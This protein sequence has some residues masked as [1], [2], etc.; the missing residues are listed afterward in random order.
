MNREERLVDYLKDKNKYIHNALDW[1]EFG[2]KKGIT[3][4][5]CQRILG[6]TELRKSIS[7]L[8]HKYEIKD[9]WEYETNRFGVPVKFKRYFIIG[10][11][12]DKQCTGKNNW[13]K[14]I[15]SGIYS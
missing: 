3:C 2:E 5:E 7:M 12:K 14:R 15:L 1:R 13:F 11:R 9:T 8:R 6:S 4:R 10:K